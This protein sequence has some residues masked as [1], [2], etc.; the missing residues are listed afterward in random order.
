MPS[1]M[2]SPSRRIVQ[3][4]YPVGQSEFGNKAYPPLILLK[5]ILIQKWFAIKSDPDLECQINDR[6]S[7]K[8]F[9]CLPFS[10][11]FPDHSIICRFRERIGKDM[12]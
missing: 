8:S 1:S 12:M 5:A 10:E 6:F 3:E 4:N 2:G 7:F 11:P 9:I